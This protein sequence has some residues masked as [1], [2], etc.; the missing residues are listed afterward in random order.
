WRFR[1]VRR[2]RR[3]RSAPCAMTPR[4]AIVRGEW[5]NPF[6]LQSYEPLLG[7][8]DVFGIGARD[9]SYELHSMRVPIV[10]LRRAGRGRVARRVI[11]DRSARLIG[12]ERVLSGC[13]IV[14]SAET[15]RPIS[16]Q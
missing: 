8:Y 11:G 10:R 7:T 12:L 15:F 16:E 2:P 9:G 5:L 3:V 1:R 4:V 14:H 13:A 6:E